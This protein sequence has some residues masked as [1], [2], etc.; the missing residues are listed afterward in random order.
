MNYQEDMQEW[1]GK[2][3]DEKGPDHEMN[4]N[5]EIDLLNLALKKLNDDKREILVLSKF[6]ELKYEEIG[7]ILDLSVAAVKVRVH[8]AMNKLKTVYQSLETI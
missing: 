1:E 7:S 3:K 4:R 6:Q 2:F 8:R 5:Q